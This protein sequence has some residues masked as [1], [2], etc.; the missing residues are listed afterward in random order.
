MT[1][2]TFDERAPLQL[3]RSVSRVALAALL[4][5]VLFVAAFMIGRVSAPTHTVRSVVTVPATQSVPA[6]A[7]DNCRAGHPC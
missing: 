4:A 5:I 6:P 1:T 3:L 2:I 7:V